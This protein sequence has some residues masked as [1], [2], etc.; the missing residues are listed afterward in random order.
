[1]S[2]DEFCKTASSILSALLLSRQPLSLPWTL[3]I[4]SPPPAPPPRRP[5]FHLQT[6]LPRRQVDGRRRRPPG[7][8][9]RAPRV[10]AGTSRKTL[11]ETKEIE[12]VGMAAL[13][14][15]LVLPLA[16]NVLSFFKL[17]SNLFYP[18]CASRRALCSLLSATRE[19]ASTRC[20]PPR[21]KCAR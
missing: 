3:T 5:L 7:P 12:R 20:V 21:S 6:G 18:R 15:S 4:T 10:R 13:V 2:R 9:R 14:P 11:I 19:C 16:D 17:S 8:R 1:M